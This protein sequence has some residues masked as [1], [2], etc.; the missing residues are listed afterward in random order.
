[1]Q[2]LCEANLMEAPPIE[3]TEAARAHRGLQQVAQF[4]RA[5]DGDAAA[6]EDLAAPITRSGT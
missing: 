1:M 3:K 4:W 5:E 2:M 6:L